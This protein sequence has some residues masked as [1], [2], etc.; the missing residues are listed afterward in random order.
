MAEQQ[1]RVFADWLSGQVQDFCEE[2]EAVYAFTFSQPVS[3]R[4]RFVQTLY[5]HVAR[6]FSLLDRLSL[7]LSPSVK[8]TVRMVTTL[9]D[10]FGVS[11]EAANVSVKLWRHGLM[12]TG[13]ARSITEQS[14][15]RYWW[16]L[17]WGL[18]LPRDQQWTVV[19]L[20]RDERVLNLALIPLLQQF[21]SVV[22]A[23]VNAL[24]SDPRLQRAAE[25]AEARLVAE[26]A[27]FHF[28]HL[29]ARR[30]AER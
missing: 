30:P 11:E 7:S 25:E 21:R 17:H 5:A 23:Y 8:Q 19:D 15:R 24:S 26:A 16:L 3:Q 9:E 1:W 12:H 6:A 20:S 4:G 29:P 13:E 28:G 2:T 27:R 22:T 18:E 10:W 14:G